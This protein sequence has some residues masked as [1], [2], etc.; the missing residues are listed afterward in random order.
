MQVI[1]SGVHAD[2]INTFKSRIEWRLDQDVVHNFLYRINWNRRCFNL[3]VMLLK[4][5]AK[6]DTCALVRIGYLT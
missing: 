4:I 6:R 1:D 5:W 2:A 3:Y